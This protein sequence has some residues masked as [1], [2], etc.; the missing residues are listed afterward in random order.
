MVLEEGP[1]CVWAEGRFDPYEV[2][3]KQVLTSPDKLRVMGR[4]TGR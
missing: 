3:D 2:L 4:S 1:L